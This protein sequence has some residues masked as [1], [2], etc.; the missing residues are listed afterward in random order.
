MPMGI[1]DDAV[2]IEYWRHPDGGWSAFC[3]LSS[4]GVGITV[5]APTEDKL[6]LNAA[7]GMERLWEYLSRQPALPAGLRLLLRFRNHPLRFHRIESPAPAP[8]RSRSIAEDA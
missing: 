7:T 3:L 4:D 2:E 1:T 5:G 6:F 8:R